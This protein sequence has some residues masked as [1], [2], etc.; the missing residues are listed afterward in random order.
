MTASERSAI[1]ELAQDVPAIWKATTTTN[2]ERK[3]LLRLAIEAV[4]LDGSQNSGQVE[5]Q[6]HWRT[7]VITTLN[8]K[9]PAPGDGSLKTPPQAVARIHELAG[10]QTY[11]EIAEQLN[12]EGLS[13][14]FHRPF[15]QYHV[16][17]ICRRDGIAR[18]LAHHQD[19]S[20][21][22]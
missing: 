18:P 3:Q 20:A 16:G 5:I 19:S 4:Q 14:A 12:R 13:S 22:S 2:A 8:V 21:E 9:R 11:A 1:I 15:S 6:I 10:R 7:G 17:Y